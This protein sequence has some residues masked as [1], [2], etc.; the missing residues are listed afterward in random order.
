MEPNT[1]ARWIL[2]LKHWQLFTF[3]VAPRILEYLFGSFRN[4]NQDYY[5]IELCYFTYLLVLLCGWIYFTTINLYPLLPANLSM[6][7]GKFKRAMAFSFFPAFMLLALALYRETEG[8]GG[9]GFFLLALLIGLILAFPVICLFYA[10]YFMIKTLKGVE[11]QRPITKGDLGFMDFTIL[12]PLIG[13]W[14][15]QPRI[16][17]VYEMS[18]IM[19]QLQKSKT[20]MI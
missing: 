12:Y 11:L 16:N 10:M 3:I 6:N 13:V 4:P 15:L 2:G 14:L 5:W 18:N 9:S 8:N 20:S 7:L 19:Q 1:N 17:H